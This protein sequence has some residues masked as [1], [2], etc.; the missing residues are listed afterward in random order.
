MEKAH[1]PYAHD[2]VED[3]KAE[4][5]QAEQMQALQQQ[6]AQLSTEIEQR[7]G[8]EDYLRGEI[9]KNGN[10]VQTKQYT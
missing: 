1:Y 4:I 6:N 2:I 8:Y 9:T 7:K 5:E 3:L 10:N